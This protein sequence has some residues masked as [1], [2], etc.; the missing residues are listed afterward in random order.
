MHLHLAAVYKMTPLQTHQTL[1]LHRH[2]V[3]IL[4][5]K[6]SKRVPCFCLY[7]ISKHDTA[8]NHIN[9]SNE[10]SFLWLGCKHCSHLIAKKDL[11]HK[12][13]FYVLHLPILICAGVEGVCL[14]CVVGVFLCSLRYSQVWQEAAN[15]PECNLQFFYIQRRQQQQPGLQQ[16]F[17]CKKKASRGDW[18]LL[19]GIFCSRK[20]Q[21]T[22]LCLFVFFSL[23]I[24][25]LN[26]HASFLYTMAKKNQTKKKS[27]FKNPTEGSVKDGK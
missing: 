26:L 23:S 20:T 16:A 25:F 24:F 13:W 11:E 17:G 15:I 19:T 2:K 4:L 12:A 5:M 7:T 14:R 6:V 3:S 18:L 1:A 27:L 10:V 9:Q 21:I 22:W 8:N